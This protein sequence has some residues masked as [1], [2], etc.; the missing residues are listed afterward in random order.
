MRAFFN[1]IV[2]SSNLLHRIILCLV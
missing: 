2:P 1:E